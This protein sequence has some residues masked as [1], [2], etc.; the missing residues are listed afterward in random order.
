[1]ALG[2][3]SHGPSPPLNIRLPIT[4]A[5]VLR[6]DSAATTSE[7]TLV[8]RRRGHGSHE[9]SWPRRPTCGAARRLCPAARERM[10][11]LE[12]DYVRGPRVDAALEHVEVGALNR[13]EALA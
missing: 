11:L 10:G 12:R 1:A 6:S 8:R 3:S 4:V 7:S 2:S 9:S 5:P 13:L